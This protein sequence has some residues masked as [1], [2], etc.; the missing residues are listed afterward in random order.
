MAWL[1]AAGGGRRRPE[2]SGIGGTKRR[3]YGTRRRPNEEGTETKWQN[4]SPK[5][6]RSWKQYAFYIPLTLSCV[7]VLGGAARLK[8]RA[9]GEDVSKR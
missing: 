7:G 6:E 1:E 9:Y 3:S 2:A 5:S 4:D 8:Q